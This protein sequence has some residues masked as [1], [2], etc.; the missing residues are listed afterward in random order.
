[1][2][3]HR[4]RKTAWVGVGRLLLGRKGVSCMDD[5]VYIKGESRGKVS[6]TIGNFFQTSEA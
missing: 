2:M 6:Q 1:M 3:R 4:D 5:R